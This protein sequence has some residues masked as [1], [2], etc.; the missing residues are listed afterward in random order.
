MKKE[1]IKSYENGIFLPV[2]EAFERNTF[3]LNEYL[4]KS[5]KEIFFQM[6]EN[7]ILNAKA[8]LKDNHYC[9]TLY[10]G[11]IPIVLEILSEHIE[12]FLSNHPEIKDKETFA[13]LGAVT[14][15][16]HIYGHEMGHI[17]RGHL[18]LTKTGT[19]K[20]IDENTIFSGTYKN[21]NR[22]LTK[23]DMLQTM[24]LD[25][26]IFS[27]YFVAKLLLNILKTQKD[28]IPEAKVILSITISSLYLFFDHLA[29]IPLVKTNYPPAMVR[30]N[31]LQH[32]TIKHL[33]GKTIFS[34]AELADLMHE[35]SFNAF[36]YLVDC[37]KLN[38]SLHKNNLD[39]LSKI[40][41]ELI[42]KH[43]VFENILSVL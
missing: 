10:S 40:E 37:N 20:L 17:L 36:S 11:M 5:G 41:N 1:E 3:E 43:R 29:K 23:S 22:N 35:A 38:T 6:E 31:V 15:W 13:G 27:S 32:N 42:I 9:I 8:Q 26:D 25:A 12:F 7:F 24:E 34:D 2:F 21:N 19:I 16:H 14:I 28:N 30:L 4:K 18:W 33:S 39:E